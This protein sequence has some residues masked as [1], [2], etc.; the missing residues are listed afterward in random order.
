MARRRGGRGGGDGR[1]PYPGPGAPWA[2]EVPSGE[3]HRPEEGTAQNP[4]ARLASWLQ[5]ALNLRSPE[6]PKHLDVEKVGLWESAY[7]EGWAIAEY[8]RTVDTLSTV[9]PVPTI[10][11]PDATLI[12]RLLYVDA[13]HTA[14]ADRTLHLRLARVGSQFLSVLEATIPVGTTRTPVPLTAPIII[15][16]AWELEALNIDIVGAETMN[17]VTMA[18]EMPVGFHAPAL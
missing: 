5:G 4:I 9:V 2:W 15:P 7:Q 12:R 11:A 10:Y 16:P 17:I 13:E 1:R 8:P 6:V 18:V 3:V 14:A